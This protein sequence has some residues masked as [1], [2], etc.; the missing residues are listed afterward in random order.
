MAVNQ[1]PGGPPG[2]LPVDLRPRRLSLLPYNDLLIDQGRDDQYPINPSGFQLTLGMIYGLGP[3]EM[4]VLRTDDAGNLLVSS[5]GAASGINIQQIN[6]QPLSTNFQSD[7][8]NSGALNAALPVG[9]QPEL[10]NGGFLD[11]GRSASA[12]NLAALSGL[13]SA[14][15]ASPGEWSV[16]ANAALGA[17]SSASRVAGGAGVRHIC[18]GYR[19]VVSSQ[20]A[21]GAGTLTINLRDGATGV[22][23]ILEAFNLQIP[24]ALYQPIIISATGLSIVGT[25]ATAMTL[26]SSAAYA[27]VGVSLNLE[28]Y[29]AS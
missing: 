11:R 14:L 12:A 22:G 24:A 27:A 16:P 2:R 13:G 7:G 6:G 3:N 1:P 10:Y 15:V 29:D 8:I 23:T 5:L 18:T 20:A 19:I 28:G 9:A 26:E 17:A 21:P 25:A 4:R